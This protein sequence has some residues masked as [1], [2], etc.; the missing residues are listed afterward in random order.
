MPETMSVG[1]YG[2]CMFSFIST[3]PAVF[4]SGCTLYLEHPASLHPHQHWDR[5]RFS[6]S[7]GW[8]QDSLPLPKFLEMETREKGVES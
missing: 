4:Q 3:G 6:A 8:E 5:S 2:K 7:A 1:L